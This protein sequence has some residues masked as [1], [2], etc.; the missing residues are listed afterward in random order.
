[1]QQSTVAALTKGRGQLAAMM[2]WLS[3]RSKNSESESNSR[4]L[5]SSMH[6]SSTKLFPSGIKLLY[7]TDS[8]V[9]ECVAFSPTPWSRNKNTG[10]Y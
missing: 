5:S 2:K 6:T 1:M 4:S 8:C 7:E 10:T 3:R 9:L